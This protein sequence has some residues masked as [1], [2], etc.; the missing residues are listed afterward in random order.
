M[1]FT[2]E[3]KEH[4]IN[5]N[6]LTQKTKSISKQIIL[7]KKPSQSLDKLESRKKKIYRI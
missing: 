4:S 5:I 2:L 1:Q 7:L 6:T 3:L